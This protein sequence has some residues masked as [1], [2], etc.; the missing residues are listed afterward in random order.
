LNL[1]PCFPETD[2]KAEA[3]YQKAGELNEFTSK[4]VASFNVPKGK[5]DHI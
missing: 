4:S 5:T 3:S 2:Q 1:P